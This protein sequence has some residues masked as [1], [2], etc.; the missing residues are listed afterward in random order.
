MLRLDFLRGGA[1]RKVFVDGRKISFLAAELGFQ[2]LE[3]DLRT[4]DKKEE[5]LKKM[6][7]KGEDLD[8]IKQLSLLGN[9]DE[10]AKDIIKDFRKT[11]WKY[12]ERQRK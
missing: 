7:L 11:G 8:L 6:N 3:I 4:L 10:I 1:I 2:P 9:E 5:E 12:I